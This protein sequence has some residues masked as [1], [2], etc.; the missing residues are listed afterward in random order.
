M[1]MA[2][3]GVA[4]DLIKKIAIPA[5]GALLDMMTPMLKDEL[6]KFLRGWHE[7]ALT[8][9]TPIDDI[10]SEKVCELFGVDLG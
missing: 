5:L 3:R 1:K 9:E 7:K 2:I 6:H 8:T 10:L 4:W